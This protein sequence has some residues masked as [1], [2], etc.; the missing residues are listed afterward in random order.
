MPVHDARRPQLAAAVTRRLR[1]RR[2]S[3]E[4]PVEKATVAKI[5]AKKTSPAKKTAAPVTKTA[6]V[7]KAAA[8]AK[9]SAAPAKKVNPHKLA[10]AEV[11][12]EVQGKVHALLEDISK[13]ATPDEHT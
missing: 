10:Q 3:D 1:S 9:K 7:K 6:A 8:P 13:S 5:P 2:E 11:I 12:I 4:T